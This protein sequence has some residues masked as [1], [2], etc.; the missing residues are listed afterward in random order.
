MVRPPLGM[1][2][3]EAPT[4]YRGWSHV[5][6]GHSGRT[7]LVGFLLKLGNVRPTGRWK[8]QL[9]KNSEE[10]EWDLAEEE[11]LLGWGQECK[12]LPNSQSKDTGPGATL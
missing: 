11:S 9:G 2:E 1:V 4:R 5:E 10:P 12:F 8:A 6:G 7:D 3:D